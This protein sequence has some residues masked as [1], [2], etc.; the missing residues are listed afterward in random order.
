MDM[1]YGVE[2]SPSDFIDEDEWDIKDPYS[3]YYSF[4]VQRSLGT[5]GIYWCYQGDRDSGSPGFFLRLRL[6]HLNIIYRRYCIE[7]RRI[8][9]S[10]ELRGE[11]ATLLEWT[12]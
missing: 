10:F 12:I 1:D 3:D 2:H 7:N 6:C 9:N 8:V 11:D 4:G 5:V